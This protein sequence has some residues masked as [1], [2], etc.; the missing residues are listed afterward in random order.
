MEVH[1]APGAL[2]HS[3]CEGLDDKSHLCLQWTSVPEPHRSPQ[4]GNVFGKERQKDAIKTTDIKAK[5]NDPRRL[6]A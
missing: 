3:H 5:A 2:R 6:C 4:S 1:M